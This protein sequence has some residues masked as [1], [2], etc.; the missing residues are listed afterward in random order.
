[1]DALTSAPTEETV[2]EYVSIF[3]S[4]DWIT[5]VKALA[6]LL[7]GFILVKLLLKGV[8]KGL[9]QSHIPPTV[10][11]MILTLLRILL[12][13]I[14]ILSAANEIGIPVTSFI[15][16]LSLA[17]LAVSLAVQGILSNFASG[18]IVLSSHPF[19][20]GHFIEHDSVTGT[21]REIRML[22]TRL[23]TPDG[24]MIYVPNSTLASSRVINYSETGKRR[25]EISVSASYNNSPDQVKAAI[26]SAVQKTPGIL[27]DPRPMIF[28][29]SYGD[30][31]INYRLMVWVNGADFLTVK[32]ALN[33]ALY[34]A[35]AEHRVE[36]TYPHLNVH[37]EP[38][39][40][41]NTAP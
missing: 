23:E 35:F 27:E 13:V 32:N 40:R 22:H 4:I 3:S 6:I 33:E 5:G 17:G 18:F 29:D 2:Q 9:K 38:L 14:V 36:M 26:Q 8:R 37:M 25:V 30:S 24:K 31:A 16:L 19:E 20:V 7:I 34:T 41:Q 12:D 1:M 11:S 28:L 10:H 21:V 15:A 39:P